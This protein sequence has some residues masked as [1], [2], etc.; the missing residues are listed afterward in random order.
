[1]IFYDSLRDVPF[2]TA[3]V[4]MELGDATQDEVYAFAG[5]NYN[6]LLNGQ[7]ELIG[8]FAHTLMHRVGRGGRP[9]REF[10]ALCMD[11]TRE[12]NVTSNQDM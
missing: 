3:M 9:L 6:S 2:Y 10:K 8:P 5:R 12:A 11:L 1:M 7:E 4:C